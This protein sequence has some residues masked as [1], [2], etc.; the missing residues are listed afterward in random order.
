MY[1]I[2]VRS[3]DVVRESMAT[4][5]FFKT[6]IDTVSKVLQWVPDD[7]IKELK[8][9]IRSELGTLGWS[10]QHRYSSLSQI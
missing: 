10:D 8:S 6:M 3:G 1:Q 9:V 5:L 4:V 2:P 7:Q